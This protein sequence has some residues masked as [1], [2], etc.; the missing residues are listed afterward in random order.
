MSKSSFDKTETSN[1]KTSQSIVHF[2]FL[3]RGIF[4]KK[5]MIESLVRI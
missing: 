1:G 5:N 4:I 2:S 3:A